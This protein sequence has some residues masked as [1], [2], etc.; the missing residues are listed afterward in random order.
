MFVVYIGFGDNN[1]K[2]KCQ[3]SK[4]GSMLF[5]FGWCGGGGGGGNGTGGFIV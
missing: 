1:A 4:N 5:S 2:K 3:L